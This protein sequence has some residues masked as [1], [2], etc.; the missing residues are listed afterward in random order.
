MT[1]PAFLAFNEKGTDARI[2]MRASEHAN[3]VVDYRS[4]DDTRMIACRPG[5]HIMKHQ[6]NLVSRV[7]LRSVASAKDRRNSVEYVDA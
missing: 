1:I 3:N 2:I 6:S 7:G 5:A 4:T